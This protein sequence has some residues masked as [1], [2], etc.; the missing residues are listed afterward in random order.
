MQT[1]YG[2]ASKDVKLQKKVRDKIVGRTGVYNE[3]WISNALLY[4]NLKTFWKYFFIRPIIHD[5]TSKF[6]RD[7]FS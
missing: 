4:S 3:V 1:S 5:L 2:I 6:F 7:Q